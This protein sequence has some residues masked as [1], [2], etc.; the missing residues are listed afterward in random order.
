MV[1]QTF[2]GPTTQPYLPHH[3]FEAFTRRYLIKKSPAYPPLHL[4]DSIDSSVFDLFV[5]LFVLFI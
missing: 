2:S 5:C 4:V 1:L 3:T